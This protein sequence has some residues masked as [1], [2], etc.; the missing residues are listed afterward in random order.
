MREGMPLIFGWKVDF[1]KHPNHHHDVLM[2]CWWYHENPQHKSSSSSSVQM[3]KSSLPRQKFQTNVNVQA[4]CV[5]DDDQ[6]GTD[7][8]LMTTLSFQSSLPHFHLKLFLIWLFFRRKHKGRVIGGEIR[9]W[10]RLLPIGEI[11]LVIIHATNVTNL[12]H[13]HNLTETKVDFKI[14]VMLNYL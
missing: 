1:A 14:E 5:W 8:E 10:G 3:I 6:A 2:T 13:A 12:K 9:L 7:Y 4:W 11:K